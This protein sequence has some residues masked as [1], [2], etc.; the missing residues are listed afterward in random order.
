[1]PK[2]IIQIPCLNEAETLGETLAALPRT[3]P[4]VDQVEVLVVDDGSAWSLLA[5]QSF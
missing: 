3:V 2:M 4:G 5:T 1:M